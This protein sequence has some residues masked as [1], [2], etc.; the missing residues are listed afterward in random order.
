MHHITIT[1][2]GRRIVSAACTC[3][4]AFGRGKTAEKG[5]ANHIAGW[6]ATYATIQ[7]T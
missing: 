7:R 2:E 3:G 4:L 6:N 5:A 1:A